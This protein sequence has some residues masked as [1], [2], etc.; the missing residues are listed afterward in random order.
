MADNSKAEDIRNGA[1]A[2]RKFR[3]QL[4]RRRSH[5]KKFCLQN[6]V[7]DELVA[8]ALQTNTDDAEDQ[9]SSKRDR[10]PVHDGMRPAG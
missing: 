10:V 7:T 4:I 2:S 3:A 9:R 1:L 8:A 5:D 6:L